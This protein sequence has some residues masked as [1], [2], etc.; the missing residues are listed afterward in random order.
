[1]LKKDAL[2]R[3]STSFVLDLR[4]GEKRKISNYAII[5]KL[6]GLATKK[7]N[8]TLCLLVLLQESKKDPFVHAFTWRTTCSALL[9]QLESSC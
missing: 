3:S 6:R 4:F 7:G 1:M 9:E 8:P 5:K 2:V